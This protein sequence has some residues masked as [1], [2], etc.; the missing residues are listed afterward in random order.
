MLARTAS[1]NH[2]GEVE[3]RE[4]IPTRR[5]EGEGDAVLRAAPNPGDRVDMADNMG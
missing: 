4:V 5:K 3:Q 2:K 1:A